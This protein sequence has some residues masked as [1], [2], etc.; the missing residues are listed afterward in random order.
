MLVFYTCACT[1]MGMFSCMQ[2]CMFEFPFGYISVLFVLVCDP[3]CLFTASV[4]TVSR[5]P[6][7]DIMFY[8]VLLSQMG[9]WC[10]LILFFCAHYRMTKLMVIVAK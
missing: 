5:I 8:C 4:D 1:L 2:V 3:V 7:T 10:E 6:V 9:S